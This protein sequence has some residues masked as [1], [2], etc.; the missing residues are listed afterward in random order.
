MNIDLNKYQPLQASKQEAKS[1]SSDSS[2]WAFL[3]K[4]IQLFGNKIGLKKKEAFYTELE[5]LLKAGLDLKTA[6]EMVQDEQHKERDKALFEKVTGNV[7]HGSSL[8]VALEQTGQFSEYEVSSI[9]IAEESGKLPPILAELASFFSK[10]LQYRRL[11]ISALSYPVL[12][13]GVAILS[14][15]FLLTF[16]VPIFGDIYAR[17]D[18]QLPVLTLVIVRLSGFVKQYAFTGLILLSAI[19]FLLSWLRN[20]TWLRKFRSSLLLFIPVFGAL[21][22]QLYLARFCQAMAFMLDAKV[23][24][25]NALQLTQ[26]MVGFY[27]IEVS[28]EKVRAGIF[29]GKALHSCLSDFKVYPKRMVSLVKVGEEANQLDTMFAKLADQYSNEVEQ[30]TKL[31]GSLIEP[32]MIVFL[33]IVVGLVLIAMYLPIFKLVTN[34]GL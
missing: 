17:L 28:L 31:L 19:G 3:N 2:L 6:L 18:Q 30:H 5:V 21:L 10:N 12:V 16:L 20:R 24:V 9:R 14:L 34:F 25:L 7:I 26:N 15:A 11:L 8:S 23:P 27:P 33:A 13:I 1:H 4:D 32:I 22:Q 29:K